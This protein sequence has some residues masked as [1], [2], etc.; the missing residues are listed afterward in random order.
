MIEICSHK[1]CPHHGASSTTPTPGSRIDDPYTLRIDG[2]YTLRI[3]TDNVNV[4]FEC[5]MCIHARKFDMKALTKKK[6]AK[7]MLKQ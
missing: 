2:P 6:L 1:D 4:A 5:L 7:N 3:I